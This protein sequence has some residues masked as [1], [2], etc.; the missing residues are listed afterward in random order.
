MLL[1]LTSYI[2]MPYSKTALILPLTDLETVSGSF[3]AMA[4]A[5]VSISGCCTGLLSRLR[6]D[7]LIVVDIRL[8]L[9]EML[10]LNFLR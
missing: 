7:A 4:Q 9:M 2:W 3:Q 5:M 8:T 6:W 1:A 10:L